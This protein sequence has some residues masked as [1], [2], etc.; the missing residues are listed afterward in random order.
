M[1]NEMSVTDKYKLAAQAINKAGGTPIPTNDTLL[2]ILT[3]FIL[4]DELDLVTAFLDQKSQTIEQLQKSS[5]LPEDEIL[6]KTDALAARGVIFNQPNRKGIM[7]YR[8]LPLIN[9]GTFEY[10]FMGKLEDNQRN[11]EISALFKKLFAE[12]RQTLDKN[13]DALAP[14]F[15]KAPP[16]D[17]TVPVSENKATGNKVKIMVNQSIEAP[18]ERIMPAQDVEKIIAKFD[19]IAVGHCFCRHYKDMLGKSCQQT[20][21]R[22]ACFTF[23]KSA[24]YTSSQGFARMISK[25]EALDILKQSEEAG[26]VHK[27][28]HPNFDIHKDETSICNCC[29]CCCGNSVDNSHF[30]VTNA[31]NYLAIIDQEVCVGCGT[32]VEKCHTHAAFLN[33]DGKADRVEDRCIGCGIC[34]SLCPPNAISLLE[35]ERIVRIEPLRKE[36]NK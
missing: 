2:E 15:L 10:T 17:R 28:Y 18:M 34:A 32:C 29:H 24:R 36:K 21:E 35:G 3:Y 11:R 33:D 20:D 7:V 31:T 1:S 6:A 27:A 4:E 16:V 23:G 14:L 26:L 9:V 8:L 30:P 25:Q 13:Y 5:G 12:V 19:E 22:E